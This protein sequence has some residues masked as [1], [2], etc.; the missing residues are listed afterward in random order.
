MNIATSIVLPFKE[1]TFDYFKIVEI[2]NVANQLLKVILYNDISR[3]INTENGPKQNG[4]ILMKTIINAT[5]DQKVVTDTETLQ[6]VFKSL[7][8]ASVLSDVPVDYTIHKIK[9]DQKFTDKR[10]IFDKF[11]NFIIIMD[12]SEIAKNWQHILIPEEEQRENEKNQ[13]INISN[14]YATITI[15]SLL[16]RHEPIQDLFYFCPTKQTYYHLRGII[17]RKFNNTFFKLNAKHFTIVNSKLGFFKIDHLYV[18]V[19]LKFGKFLKTTENRVA[20]EMK[21]SVFVVEDLKYEVIEK[22][23]L[24]FDLYGITP[25]FARK[26]IFGHDDIIIIFVGILP[27]SVEQDYLQFLI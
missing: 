12:E 14:Q 23:N 1:L 26:S 25:N 4:Y 10:E 3:E 2:R 27:V 15:K 11:R 18:N 21:N 5:N 20:H 16:K 19:V 8:D 24:L 13:I 22:L 7:M 9:Y 6:F 17:Y